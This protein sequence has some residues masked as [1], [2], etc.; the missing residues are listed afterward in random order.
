LTFEDGRMIG[1]PETLVRNYSYLL[2]K[3]PE[4]RSSQDYFS[5]K[6]NAKN[7]SKSKTSSNTHTALVPILHSE[8]QRFCG[9]RNVF[10]KLFDLPLTPR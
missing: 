3:S 1:C 7:V 6:N 8:A 4:E 10:V 5:H 9:H 2:C